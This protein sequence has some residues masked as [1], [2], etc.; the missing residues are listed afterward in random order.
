MKVGI[1]IDFVCPYCFVDMEIMWKAL[2]EKL[3][4]MDIVWYPYELAPEPSEQKRVDFA[5]EKYF[6]EK[7]KPW[8]E[9][10]GVKVNFP[11]IDPVP[12]TAL[13]FEGIKIAM[14]YNL[15]A[16]FVKN[17]FE[18][19]WLENKN[20]GDIEV[21]SEIAEKSRIPKEDFKKSLEIGEFRN[22]HIKENSE[23]S[24][25]DFEVVPTF[26]IDGKQISEFPRTLEEMKK[27]LNN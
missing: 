4:D 2:G 20:I 19:Y 23:V 3:E 18:S 12:R 14:K 26:Y 7:I 21:L 6:L 15:E 13:A 24:D 16:H 25:W 5:R 27:L 8:A 22:E 9:K 11:T 10:E 1:I 17:V